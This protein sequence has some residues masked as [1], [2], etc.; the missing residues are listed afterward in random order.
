MKGRREQHEEGGREDDS[1][2]QDKKNKRKTDLRSA[3]LKPSETQKVNKANNNVLL[4]ICENIE[5]MVAGCFVPVWFKYTPTCVQ[6]K[7]PPAR[8]NVDLPEEKMALN[9]CYERQ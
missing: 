9:V 4:L 8:Q 3:V 6:R 1:T 2:R 5:L 7:F